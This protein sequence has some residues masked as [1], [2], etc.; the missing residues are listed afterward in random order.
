MSL[1]KEKYKGRLFY[2]MEAKYSKTKINKATKDLRDKKIS[3]CPEQ[4]GIIQNYR[5]SHLIPLDE[6]TDM[7]KVKI[8][9]LEGL[10]KK[11]QLFLGQKN[12]FYSKKNEYWSW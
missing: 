6:L 11:P 3:K 2:L 10:Q 9:K 1:N 12:R 5:N 4:V 8:K 7:L